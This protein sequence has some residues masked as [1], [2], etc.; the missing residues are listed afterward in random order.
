MNKTIMVVL[1]GFGYSEEE[2]GNAILKAKMDHFNELYETFPHSLLET[3]GENVDT[4]E[5]KTIDCEVAHLIMGAGRSVKQD[6]TLCNE[7]L[8]STLI[9]KNEKLI[10][11]I[12]NLYRNSGALHLIGLVSDGKVY[13][14][15]RYMKNFIAHLKNMGLKK[16]YFHAITDGRDVMPNSANQYL[17]D[18]IDVMNLNELGKVVSICGRSSAM[19]RSEDYKKTKVFTDLIIKGKGVPIKNFHSAIDTCY[20]RNVTDEII[21]PII[22]DEDGTIK[23][24]DAVIWLNFREDRARQTLNALANKEFSEYKTGMPD[25]VKVFSLLKIE[26]IDGLD[27]L[28]D[29]DSNE[30]SVGKYF[31][32][33]GLKQA[34][35]SEVDK[36]V[37]ISYYFN[38]CEDKK[39]KYCD[40]F[41]IPSYEKKDMIKF[42]ALNLDGLTDRVIKC[43]EHDYD[44]ILVNIENP[45]LFGHTGNMDITVEALKEVDRCIGKI[46][47]AVNDNFYKLIITSDH[48]NVEEMINEDGTPNRGHTNNL[49][50]FII[51]D[52]HVKLKDKGII[53]QIAPTLLKYMNIAIPKQM[54]DTKVLFKLDL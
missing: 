22:L 31:S 54:E 4:P 53:T 25:D 27:Y 24:G 16:L 12:E 46:Y 13:S 42:P 7:V 32:D 37:N 29:K 39:L 43:L 11:I 1:D 26:D 40:N 10:D 50:P 6:I 52:K 17:D 51:C 41:I 49:V 3:A 15:I 9:E 23:P 19:D 48:G 35:I 33:L 30:Y 18:L 28:I 47:D 45:D 21:P 34:R 2:N 14:D 20:K 44:F 8:G 5:D 38:G 36:F